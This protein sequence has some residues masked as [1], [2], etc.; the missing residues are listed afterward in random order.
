QAA[1]LS[2]L[3]FQPP[4]GEEEPLRVC[5]VNLQTLPEPRHL[6]PQICTCPPSPRRRREPGNVCTGFCS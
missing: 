1:G 5:A 2:L 6:R 4:A 3:C